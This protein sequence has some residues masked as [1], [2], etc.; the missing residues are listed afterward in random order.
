MLNDDIDS[1]GLLSSHHTPLAATTTRYMI[2][3]ACKVDSFEQVVV[4][5]G[6]CVCF[7]HFGMLSRTPPY[8][9]RSY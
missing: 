8:L 6:G 7:F 9:F 3:F 4:A 5:A 2:Q 1:S